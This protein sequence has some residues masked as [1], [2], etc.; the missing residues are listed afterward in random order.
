MAGPL[1]TVGKKGNPLDRILIG[2]DPLQAVG[3]KTGQ[4]RMFQQDGAVT[5]FPYIGNMVQADE[6]PIHL[7]RGYDCQQWSGYAVQELRERSSPHKTAMEI[8]NII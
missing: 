3:N 4:Q 7:Y 2:L 6:N 1:H 8:S 5:V